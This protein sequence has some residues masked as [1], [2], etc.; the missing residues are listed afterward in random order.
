MA[1]I[2][3]SAIFN[4]AI[5]NTGASAATT[6]TGTG[7]IDAGEGAG[8]RRRD[9]P[10]KPLGLPPQRRRKEAARRAVDERTDEVRQIHQEARREALERAGLD[11]AGTLEIAAKPI[12]QMS[13]SEINAEIGLLLRIQQSNDDA[14]RLMILL[15]AA[16][17]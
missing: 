12:E 5:F 2:F 3:N 11:D 8:I 13:I 15:L 4:N 14:E 9:L 6:P 7:G 17:S 10:A 16:E 1:G